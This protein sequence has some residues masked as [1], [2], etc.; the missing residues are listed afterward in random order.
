MICE[1]CQEE[2]CCCGAMDQAIDH[3]LFFEGYLDDTKM[4]EIL[5]EV[6]DTEDLQPYLNSRID[7][8]L[9]GRVTYMNNRYIYFPY[10]RLEIRTVHGTARV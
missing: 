3:H 6:C 10:G 5:H 4:T 8:G 1:L 2:G 9:I 7:N